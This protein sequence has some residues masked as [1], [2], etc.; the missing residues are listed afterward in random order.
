M[1]WRGLHITRP[2]SLRLAQNQVVVAQDEGD[3]RIPLEDIAWIILDTQQ[4]TSL[5]RPDCSLYG[6]GHRRDC[7]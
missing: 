1:A 2:A 5:W 6:G 4:T 7:L 3:V